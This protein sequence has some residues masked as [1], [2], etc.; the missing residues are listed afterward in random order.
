MRDLGMLIELK[1]MKRTFIYT[2]FSLSFSLSLFTFCLSTQFIYSILLTSILR[3]L[4]KWNVMTTNLTKFLFPVIFKKYKYVN[5]CDRLLILFQLNPRQTSISSKWNRIRPLLSS[6]LLSFRLD[7]LCCVDCLFIGIY[8]FLD[9]N[10]LAFCFSS[11]FRCLSVSDLY[12]L[13]PKKTAMEQKE[14]K[15][16]WIRYFASN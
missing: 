6:S 9:F 4:Q 11:R 8:F 3:E 1:L 13:Y 14:R 15:Q 10:C 12:N 5:S 16:K 2:Y 7:R